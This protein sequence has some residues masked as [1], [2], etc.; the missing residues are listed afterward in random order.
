M[1]ARCRHGRCWVLASVQLIGSHVMWCPDCG[2]VRGHDWTGWVY[3]DGQAKALARY[4][5]VT[6]ESEHGTG[7][8]VSEAS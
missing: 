5:K 7:R 6:K 8:E 2:A 3:P 1:A 4:V